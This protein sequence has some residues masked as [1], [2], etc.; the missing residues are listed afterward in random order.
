LACD[1]NIEV[2][3]FNELFKKYQDVQYKDQLLMAL[4]KTEEIKGILYD[5]LAQLFKRQENLEKLVEKSKD[6]SRLSKELFGK[7]KRLHQGCSCA[8]F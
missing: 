6:L 2:K 3:G 5:T 8:I 1:D 7:A 4:L